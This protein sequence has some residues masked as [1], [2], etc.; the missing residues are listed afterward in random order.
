MF[1]SKKR[2][3]TKFRIVCA[4]VSA[5]RSVLGHSPELEIVERIEAV[6]RLWTSGRVRRFTLAV[7]FA[8]LLGA[9]LTVGL[10]RSR[11]SSV[12][13]GD[14]PAFLA[15]GEIVAAG[16]GAD[17]Y[18]P[19]LQQ[20]IQERRWPEMEGRYL[21]FAY[22]P[23]LAIVFSPLS[24]LP[25]DVAKAVTVFVFAGCVL[26]AAVAM[27]EVA[28]VVERAPVVAGLLLAMFPPV[29][30]SVVSGQNTAIGMLLYA[31]LLWSGAL[32]KGNPRRFVSGLCLALWFYKPN[33]ALVAVLLMLCCGRWREVVSG[34]AGGAVMYGLCG[35]W[36]GAGWMAGWFQGLRFFAAEDF[37]ANASQ[38]ISFVGVGRAVAALAGES[39]GQG[40][41]DLT[42]SLLSIAVVGICAWEGF[43]AARVPNNELRKRL[44]TDVLCLAGPAAV[45]CSPHM[46]Y[47]DLGIATLGAIRFMRFEKDGAAWWF[48]VLYAL[49]FAACGG[50]ELLPV[51]PLAGLAVGLFVFCW[52]EVRRGRKA[53]LGM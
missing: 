25:L 4:E 24:R 27:R 33:L 40:G 53:A 22:P 26:L 51:Q 30:G 19:H 5:Y 15:A 9:V 34:V 46:L 11:S 8:C 6:G 43:K 7:A 45:L 41:I 31:G 48:I 12:V 39:S 37:V 2:E 10:D 18:D 47:Y 16:R 35:F 3:K 50:K 44:V 13:R 17:L 36:T 28:P 21:Y 32:E 14:F 20:A 42:M 38:M 1:A 52:L 49:S 29:L 23:P